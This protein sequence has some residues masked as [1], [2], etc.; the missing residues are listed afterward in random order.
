MTIP[1]PIHSPYGRHILME[2]TDCPS[3]LLNSVDEVET[4]LLNSA[5]DGGATVIS[6]HFHSFTPQGL[7]GVIVIQESHITIHTWPEKNYAAVDVFTCGN[8]VVA[9]QV[10]KYIAERIQAK[11]VNL[12]SFSRS[13]LGTQILNLSSP[14]LKR[15]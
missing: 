1:E 9:D 7:S 5:K 12:S 2:L 10:S 13:P 14:L 4:L 3:D 11:K 8:E 15:P 6:S